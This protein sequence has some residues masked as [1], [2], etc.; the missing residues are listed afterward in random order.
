MRVRF[1]AQGHLGIKEMAIAY[2]TGDHVIV[3]WFVAQEGVPG[4]GKTVVVYDDFDS[5][6]EIDEHQ[7]NEMFAEI[8]TS[9]PEDEIPW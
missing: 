7:F 9:C 8:E 6:G 2:Y 4:Y 1:F 3:V 5:S